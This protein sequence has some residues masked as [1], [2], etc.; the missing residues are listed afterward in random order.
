VSALLLGAAL[1]RFR[2]HEIISQKQMELESI[3]DLKVHEITRWREEQITD[4]RVMMRNPLVSELLVRWLDHPEKQESKRL[5]QEWLDVNRTIR[6][7]SRMTIFDSTGTLC[8]ASPPS[9]TTADSTTIGLARKAIHDTIVVFGDMRKRVEGGGDSVHIE[10]TIPIRGSKATQAAVAALVIDIDPSRFLFPLIQT[11]PTPSRTAET[12]LLRREGQSIVFLNELRHRRQTSLAFQL[13]LDQPRLLG[14]MA[15]RGATGLLDGVDYRGIAAIGISHTIPSSPWIMI[16]K[17][18]KSEIYAPLT[19]AFAWFL[20]LALAL[21]ALSGFGVALVQR[22]LLA[23]NF[24]SLYQAEQEKGRLGESLAES[25][26]RF[27]SIITDAHAGYFFIDAEGF[28]RDV[29]KTWAKMYGYERPDEVIGKQFSL[30]Q[31]DEDITLAREVI[32]GIR[33]DETK[34]LIGEFSRKLKDG[35][36]GYH[37]F[38]A[39]PVM[40]QGTAI[41][42]EGFI[43]DTTERKTHEQ[44]LRASEARFRNIFTLAPIGMAL[45]NAEFKFIASNQSFSTLIGYSEEEI[46]DLTFK[47]ITHAENLGKDIEHVTKLKAGEIAI[48][49]TEKR[50]IHKNGKF[51]WANL[52]L[53]TIRTE[54]GAFLHF[55]AMIEDITFRKQAEAALQAE[56]ERL[57]VTLRSIGDGVITTDVTGAIVLINKVAEELTGWRQSEAQGRPLTE[58]FHIVNEQTRIRCENPVDKVLAT[59]GIVGLANHT[60]LISRDGGERVIADSGAPIRDRESAIIGVVL[61]FRDITDKQ[62]TETALQNAQKLESIGVLAG[63]IAHDFN[64]LLGGIFGYID[65]AREYFEEGDTKKAGSSLSKALN[66]LD[67]AKALTGQLLTFSKGGTPVKKTMV[68]APLLKN[69]TTFALTGSNVDA[70]FKIAEELW[71]CDIDEHQMSQVIDNIV[72]NGRQAMPNGGSITVSALNIPAGSSV[73][74]PAGAGIP[75]VRITIADQGIGIAPE[76]LSRIF[77]PFFSTK[78][79]GSGLGLATAFSIVTK[80]EGIISVESA[81]RKGSTFSIYLPAS[82]SI[83]P[84]APAPEIQQHQGQGT[85]LV[86]DDEEYMLDIAAQ[87]LKNMGYAVTCA[88]HGDEAV[89]LFA[90]AQNE[91][92]PFSLVILD[93]TIPGGMGGKETVVKLRTIDPEVRVIASSGFTEDPIMAEPTAFGFNDKLLKPYL[94]AELGAAVQRMMQERR[95]IL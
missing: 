67:R 19:A 64:N 49:Q 79:Q 32:E 58:V 27:R 7:Y 34:F 91:K 17:V 69:T 11:W 86:M 48:Y 52:T 83:A 3:A 73:P 57:L 33:R 6:K 12:L 26:A 95:S 84:K 80:H 87:L 24:R 94:K 60:A 65:L 53:S 41:G 15:A 2:A 81:L 37:T 75:Y 14:A 55:L 13:P 90:A 16:A 72:I 71:P 66:V 8:L 74:L 70:V 68:L 54:A 46:L 47:Q 77:D 4:A 25:E 36:I 10:I 85:V 40:R 62:K 93:L 45:I 20:F 28:I 59:G 1:Y 29:N 63:G 78:Q 38:S 88:A 42:I 76:H 5:L 61:V 50:Y 44:A 39:R 56:K 21:I 22:H 89:A 35:S 31:A 18:D 23:R 30:F 43:I 51:V 92:R 9:M 82:P